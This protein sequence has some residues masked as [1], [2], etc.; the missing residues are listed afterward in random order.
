MCLKKSR[1]LIVFLLGS[2]FLRKHGVSGDVGNE[3]L[4]KGDKVVVRMQS[5]GACVVY[6]LR[7][8]R[9]GE[10]YVPVFSLGGAVGLVLLVH[11]RYGHMGKFKLWECMREQ[12][13]TPW[14]QKIVNDVATTCESC[15]KGNTQRI[16]LNAQEPFDFR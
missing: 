6:F 11:K 4:M 7:K 1:C 9:E 2:E 13:C 12:L 16:E 15:Q 5:E 10:V 3:C 8:T 14:L